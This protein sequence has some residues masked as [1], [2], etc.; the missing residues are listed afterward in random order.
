[1]TNISRKRYKQ[2]VNYKPSSYAIK[3]KFCKKTSERD[4]SET[5]TWSHMQDMLGTDDWRI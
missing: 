3:D 1:M 2:S 4:R 5:F